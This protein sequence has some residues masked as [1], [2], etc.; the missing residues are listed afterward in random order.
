MVFRNVCVKVKVVFKLNIK[1][2][3]S[4]LWNLFYLF[5]MVNVVLVVK[6]VICNIIG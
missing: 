4:D 5:N 6:I 3:L 2:I 1:M